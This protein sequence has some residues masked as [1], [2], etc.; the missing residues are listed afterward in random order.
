MLRHVVMYLH[1][2]IRKKE[3]DASIHKRKDKLTYVETDRSTGKKK[4]K[5]KMKHSHVLKVMNKRPRAHR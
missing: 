2:N 3:K 1:N 5:R 4:K